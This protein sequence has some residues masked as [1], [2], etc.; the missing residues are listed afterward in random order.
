MAR[1][2]AE[3]IRGPRAPGCGGAVLHD[4]VQLQPVGHLRRQFVAPLGLALQEPG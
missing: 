4:G 1:T 3:R 2:T